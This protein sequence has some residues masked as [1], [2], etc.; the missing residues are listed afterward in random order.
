[1]PAGAPLEPGDLVFFGLGP[2]DVTHVGIYV[3]GG[4]IVDAPHAG[5][6]VRVEQA[7][8]TPG[9][10]WGQDRLVGITDP[11]LGSTGIARRR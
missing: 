6:D 4:Q 3:G 5:A 1:V 10:P 7:P 9:A 8:T 2:N 11:A